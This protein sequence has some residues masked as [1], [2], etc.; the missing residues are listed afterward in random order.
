MRHVRPSGLAYQGNVPALGVGI[1]VTLASLGALLAVLLP[2]RSHLSIAIPALVFVLPALIGVVVGGFLPGA[3]GA[4]GGFVVYDVFFLPP[5]TPSRSVAPELDR[6]GRLRRGRTDRLP[7]RGEPAECPRG[8]GTPDRRIATTVELSQA[9][10]GDLTLSEL[11]THIVADG[12]IRFRPTLDGVGPARR[13]AGHWGS[14]GSLKV[15]ASAGQPLTEGDVASVTSGGGEARSLGLLEEPGPRRV[16]VAL[17]VSHRAVGML[18]LQDVQ[19][20]ERERSLLGTFANQAALA[21][22][23]A[24]LSEQAL[25][26][27]LLEEIDRWRRALIGAASHDLRTPLASIK[28]AVSS[29]RQVDAR[30]SP[31]DRA[32]LLEL[33]E[34]QSDRLERLVSNLLDMTRLGGRRARAAAEHG[35]LPRPGRRGTGAAGR[36]RGTRPRHGRHAGEPAPLAPRSRTYGPGPGEPARERRAV[37][38]RRQRHPRDGATRARERGAGRDLGGRRRSRHRRAKTASACSRCS[39]RT[40]AGTGRPRAGHRQGLRRGARRAHL[41]RARRGAR[42]PGRLHRP[43][44]DPRRRRRSERP[45]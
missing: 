9:L 3:V 20:V 38:A 6:A 12:A 35:R 15:A 41:G 16:S 36:H 26:T 30:L 21:V 18:V 2:F 23:R 14:G 43:G 33:I 11:L 37:V 13:C 29:M 27:R 4:L 39:A 34:L 42:C 5:T 8:G 44:G 7:G 40:A 17:V 31:D 22:D 28:T 32:E 1:F 25:R 10:I 19:L 45:P 24:Q